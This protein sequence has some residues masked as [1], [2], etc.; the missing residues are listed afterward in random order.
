MDWQSDAERAR[1]LRGR[2]TEAEKVLW[3]HLRSRQLLGAKFR[4]QHPIGR[5]IVDFA[6][7]ESMLVVEADG[8]HHFA[9]RQDIERDAELKRRG[10]KVLRFW[11]P[12]IHEDTNKV[13]VK[14]RSELLR[15][16]PE[17]NSIDEHDDDRG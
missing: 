13:L 5:W 9:S 1:E 2:S 4:R 6:C 14:I 8:G 12:D 10:F 3:S 15:S 17:R 11:N 7:L 16:A